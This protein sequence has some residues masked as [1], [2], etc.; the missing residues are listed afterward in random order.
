MLAPVGV[1]RKYE[2]ISPSR[3][4]MT[5]IAAEVT[6][7]DLK[8][9]QRHMAVRAGKMISP[10][11]SMVPIILIPTTIVNAVKIAINVS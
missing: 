11:M 1:S 6:T 7:T 10:E 9:R 3:K 2:D 5:D 4:H 8:L